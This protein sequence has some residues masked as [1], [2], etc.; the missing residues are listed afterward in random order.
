MPSCGSYPS[1]AL[2]KVVGITRNSMELIKRGPKASELPSNICSIYQI[3]LDSYVSHHSVLMLF[4][5][6]QTE[7]PY[8]LT[9]KHIIYEMRE[10]P[11]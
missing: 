3:C 2:D 7:S 10:L 9:G 11:K 5:P 4:H 8:L 6:W 1:F